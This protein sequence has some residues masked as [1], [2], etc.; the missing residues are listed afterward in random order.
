MDPGSAVILE[1]STTA[2]GGVHDGVEDLERHG[3]TDPH[4]LE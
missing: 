3:V 1:Q 4:G 2:S